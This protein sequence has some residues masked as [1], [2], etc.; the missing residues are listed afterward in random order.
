MSLIAADRCKTSVVLC[1]DQ[2]AILLGPEL[3]PGIP[4]FAPRRPKLF[5]GDAVAVAVLG[6]TAA[7]GHDLDVRDKVADIALNARDLGDGLVLLTDLFEQQSEILRSETRATAA[8]A[9][10]FTVEVLTIALIAGRTSR[11]TLDLYAV[12]LLADGSVEAHRITTGRGYGPA[13]LTADIDLAVEDAR[14]AA[15]PEAAVE[16]LGGLIHDV[17]KREYK[18]ISFEWDSVIVDA[19]ICQSNHHPAPPMQIPR[20]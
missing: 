13:S 14:R 15:S 11:N 3:L 4:H 6:V 8:C 5:A 2:N 10:P 19:D 17:A 20:H 7:A 12:G 16:R 18:L 1:A 9:E